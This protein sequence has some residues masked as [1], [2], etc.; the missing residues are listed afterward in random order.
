[1]TARQ[2]RTLLAILLLVLAVEYGLLAVLYLSYEPS[3]PERKQ[4]EIPIVYD[5]PAYTLVI[6]EPTGRSWY[7]YVD[8]TIKVI[9]EGNSYE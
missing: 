7:E 4:R 2:S 5:T 3:L 9:T 8:G 6:E 1:M